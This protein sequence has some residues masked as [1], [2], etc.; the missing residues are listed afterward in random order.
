MKKLRFASFV[1]LTVVSV[2]IACAG[3]T[4]QSF[5]D[6]IRYYDAQDYPRAVAEFTTV[7]DAGVRNGKLFYNLGNAYLK[8]GDIGQALLWYERALMYMP[9]D[10]DLK[11]NL[12]YARSRVKDQAEHKENPVLQVVFFWKTLLSRTAIQWIA[13]VLN[14]IFWLLM[15]VQLFVRKRSFRLPAAI[16]LC[17]AVIFTLTA[18]YQFYV[19]RYVRYA[20][21]LPDEV[22]VRSGLSEDSTQLF[23]LHSGTKVRIDKQMDH[24]YLIRF[25][26]KKIG[27]VNIS[28]IGMI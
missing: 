25:S 14:G 2:S 1:I 17:V 7:A 13:V 4:P 18:C 21:I 26:E 27:W 3:K 28:D 20:I 9:E 5:L 6:G 10:P 15:I 23:V 16:V 19:F 12:E 24:H 11:F 22:P 8:N